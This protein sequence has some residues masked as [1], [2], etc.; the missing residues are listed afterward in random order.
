MGLLCNFLGLLVVD[1]RLSLVTVP[2]PASL[3]IVKKVVPEVPVVQAPKSV[4]VV[5]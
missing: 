2:P 3:S 5:S 4:K 1:N